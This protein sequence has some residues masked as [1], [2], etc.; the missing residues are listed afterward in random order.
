MKRITA[1]GLLAFVALSISCSKK[2]ENQS[3]AVITFMIGEVQVFKNNAWGGVETGSELYQGDRIR[4]KAGATVDVQIGQSVVRVKEKSELALAALFMDRSTNLENTSLE[5]A[6]GTVLAKPRKLIKGESFM[7]KTPTAVAGVRGTMFMVESNAAKDTRV[8]VVSGRVQ[9][10]K[11]V[12]AIE[13]IESD[14]VRDSEAVKKIEAHI[15]GSSVT[16][17]ENRAVK[18]EAKEV[19]KV[20]A[21]VE[22]MVLAVAAA[23]KKVDAPPVEIT[24]VVNE[25]AAVKAITASEM[26]DDTSLRKEFDEMKLVEL[27]EPVKEAPVEKGRVEI[28]VKPESALVYLNGEMAGSGD[29]SLEL[30]PGA[31]SMRIE[32]EG[33]EIFQKEV[34]L[35]V[36]RPFK[37]K[38]ELV[39]LRPLDR[40]R[41]NLDVKSPV[42]EMVYSGRRVFVATGDGML[43][44]FERD[45]AAKAWEKKTGPVTSGM[46]LGNN[47]LYF[48]TADEKLNAVSMET[49]ELLWSE[50]LSGAVI[51]TMT[52]V[53]TPTAVY[54]AT[55]KGMVYSFNL[56]GRQNWKFNAGAGVFETPMLANNR[57]LVSGS[58]GKLNSLAAQSGKEQWAVDIGAKFRLAF[59]RGTLYAVSY[60]GAVSALEMEKGAELWK[61]ELADTFVTA[62]LVFNNRMIVAGM[63]GAV[64]WLDLDDGSVIAKKNLGGAVRNSMALSGGVLYISANDTLFAI[65]ASGGGLQWKHQVKGRISTSASIAGNEIYVGL[66][67]GRVVSLNRNLG[68]GRQ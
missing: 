51:D 19:A 2:T 61:K 48:A 5:L 17:T 63:K 6:V 35:A 62:P 22:K 13:N 4:T 37:E 47:A 21:Q 65:D 12:A 46:A 41:W 16:V 29:V 68:R 43:M 56:R 18:V 20:N 38:I 7:V 32:A 49:G 44:A 10:F 24:R 66:D 59:Q 14:A 15:E 50:K 36:D 67:N 45:N 11:R 33:Y 64:T 53:V 9:V 25:V 34:V 54:I 30:V 55:T 8:E 26:R 28:S 40:V 27:K 42:R 57:I 58:D 60:Y 31:Y 1:I 23:E 39:R 3:R 52:A